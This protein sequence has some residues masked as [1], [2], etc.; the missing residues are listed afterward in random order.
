MVITRELQKGEKFAKETRPIN[1]LFKSWYFFSAIT[2]LFQWGAANLEKRPS[3]FYTSTLPYFGILGMICLLVVQML[4]LQ[5]LIERI[6]FKIR[7]RKNKRRYDLLS[8][9][10]KIQDYENDKAVLLAEKERK[11]DVYVSEQNKYYERCFDAIDKS[12]ELAKKK[13]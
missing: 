3:D 11:I 1:I 7:A 4:L 13:K 8:L 6:D 5:P 9:E 12:I 10:E 2:L